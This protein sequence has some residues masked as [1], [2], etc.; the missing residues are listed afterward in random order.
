[1]ATNNKLAA[2]IWNCLAVGVERF[3]AKITLHEKSQF[4]G[5][6][7]IKLEGRPGTPV[8]GFCLYLNSVGVKILKGSP[9]IEMPT[10]LASNDT[11]YD[12]FAPGTAETRA[13]LT[14]GIFADASVQAAVKTAG[15]MVRGAQAGSTA[16]AGGSNPF[17]G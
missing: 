11:R 4:L 13:V 9:Y 10:E 7:S 2:S 6:A 8:E 5:Y 17:G 15:D 16:S 1:M 3:T 12:R 14:A